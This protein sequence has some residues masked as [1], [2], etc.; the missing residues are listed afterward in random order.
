[1]PDEMRALHASAAP[2]ILAEIHTLLQPRPSDCRMEAIGSPGSVWG[3]LMLSAVRL[4]FAAIVAVFL[5]APVGAVQPTGSA[6]WTTDGWVSLSGDLR[7]G[8]GVRYD[9]TGSVDVG[10]RVRVDRCTTKRWCEIHTTSARGWLSLDNLSFGQKPDGLLAGPKFP[11]QRGG[12]VVCFYTSSGF[13]GE[14][15]CAKS[16]RVIPDLSLVGLDN[17]IASVEV[18][19]AASA[20]VCRDRFFRSYCEVVDVSKGRL[21]GLLSNGISSIRVY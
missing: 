20:V 17:T 2:F 9:V 14:S 21:D 1:M 13:S 8:P 7:S 10:A 15:F 19:G 3:C 18:N 11:T 4:L 5:A 16:G 6:A 12:G